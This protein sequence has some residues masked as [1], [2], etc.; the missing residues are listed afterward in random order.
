MKN[1]V[2]STTIGVLRY[3]VDL[4]HR[5]ETIARFFNDGC[6]VINYVACSTQLNELKWFTWVL[7][8]AASGDEQA[9]SIISIW[10]AGVKDAIEKQ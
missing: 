1:P 5:L 8:A 4:R 6:V 2:E 3:S 7:T 10:L 9:E